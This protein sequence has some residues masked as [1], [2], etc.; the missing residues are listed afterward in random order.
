MF[1]DEKWYRIA[2]I[3]D[4]MWYKSRTPVNHI[5]N[6]YISEKYKKVIWWTP[7]KRKRAILWE[8]L[9][10]FISDRDNV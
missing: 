2:E 1:E 8:G 5:M 10:N 3:R 7:K 4:I 6:K 9:N